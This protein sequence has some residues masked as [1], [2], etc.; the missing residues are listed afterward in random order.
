MKK[1]IASILSCMLPL[2]SFAMEVSHPLVEATHRYVD[3]I[4]RLNKGED[5]AQHDVAAT[6]LAPDCKKVFNGT[7]FTQSRQEFVDDLLTVY[8]THGSWNIRP[9]DILL[10]QDNNAVVMRLFVDMEKGG[11]FTEIVIVCFNAQGLIQELNI[12]FNKIEDG[13]HFEGEQQ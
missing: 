10:S 2:C 12:V 13:Y 1:L 8:R 6:L 4:N 5:F 3:F 11:H 7:I 9:A